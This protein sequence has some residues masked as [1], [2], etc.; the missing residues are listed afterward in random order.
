MYL[1]FIQLQSKFAYLPPKY[2]DFPCCC[3]VAKSC[4]TLCNPMDCSAPGFP[5]QLSPWVCW[6]SCSLSWWC[7]LTISSSATPFSFCLPS[8][9]ASGSFPKSQLFTSGGQ[10]IGTSASES[11]WK[12]IKKWLNHGS[13]NF[14]CKSQV[15]N[16]LVFADHAL[17]V[18]TT[19]FCYCRRVT[20]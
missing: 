7:Y 5:V 20:A 1:V 12:S 11:D 10:S 17:C 15:T 13:V 9:P 2:W 16:I 18:A 8:F 3:S 4:P 14:L 6:N 19:Q